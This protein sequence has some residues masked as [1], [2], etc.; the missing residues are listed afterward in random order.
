MNPIP[1]PNDGTVD[2]EFSVVEKPSDQLE[3]SAGWGGVGRGVVGS[4]GVSFNNFSVK[5]IFKRESWNPLP[6]G[7]GQRLSFRVNTN[8][9]LFQSYNMS[10]TEPW[11]GGRKPNSFT[12]S[13]FRTLQSNNIARNEVGRRSFATDGGTI[14][15]GI[16]LKWPDDY[17]S[18]LTAFSVQHYQLTDWTQSNFFLQN[19]DLY[20]LSTNF[21]LARNSA[22]PNPYFPQS[23][24]NISLSLQLT[25]P[26]S[27]LNNRNYAVLPAEQRYR[28]IE[29]HK[30]RFNAEWFTPLVGKL[31]LRTA[32]KMGFVGFYN[33]QIGHSSFEQYQL[34]GDGLANFNLEGFDVI[35]L[36][37][38]EPFQNS[39]GSTVNAPIFNK[40]TVDVRYP[41]SLNPSSTVYA[42]VFAEGGNLYTN[43]D[44]YNPFELRR[45]VGLGVRAFLPMFGLLGIDYGIRFDNGPT[46]PLLDTKNA[47]D[48]I[49]NNGRFSIILGFEPD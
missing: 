31:V 13:L 4:V 32:A 11:F 47:F 42:H 2:L 14:A 44:Q 17:F 26:Y 8:G 33:P 40:F 28:L 6:Q 20:N 21:T 23:G 37:G 34:G 22:G 27:L 7:D 18:F 9:R 35:A 19:G 30:W 1:N 24:S 15:Y 49:L 12:F 3:L 10:F 45:S 48:Y 39:N 46:E 25:P 41:I 29:Y 43:F 38:Y 16:R 36:R 5:N